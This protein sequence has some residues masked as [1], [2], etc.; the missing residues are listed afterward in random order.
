MVKVFDE[1][2]QKYDGSFDG[3]ILKTDYFEFFGTYDETP[4]AHHT[5]KLLR[6]FVFRIRVRLRA[7]YDRER[8]IRAKN[9]KAHLKKKRAVQPS[10]IRDDNASK[11]FQ[12]SP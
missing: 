6:L 1:L 9:L 10:R 5:G 11:P 12:N 2:K 4:C 3:V 8:I 7:R